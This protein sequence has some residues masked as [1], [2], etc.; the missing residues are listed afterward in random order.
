MVIPLQARTLVTMGNGDEAAWRWRRMAA[1]LPPNRRQQAA[2][3]ARFPLAEARLQAPRRRLPLLVRNHNWRVV[4]P[5]S[6]GRSPQ[7][8][9]GLSTDRSGRRRR[10]C[11]RRPRTTSDGGQCIARM[12]AN[13]VHV[14]RRALHGRVRPVVLATTP[15]KRRERTVVDRSRSPSSVAASASSVPTAPAKHDLTFMLLGLVRPSGGRISCSGG[16]P[17]IGGPWPRSVPSSSR[18]LCTLSGRDN[19]RLLADVGQHHRRPHRQ[20]PG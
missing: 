14:G 6:R 5:R 2:L 13:A 1:T 7:V 15:D 3:A 8:G 20:V 4:V 18:K 9:P 10:H 17:A 11:E 12:V 16:R 19:L